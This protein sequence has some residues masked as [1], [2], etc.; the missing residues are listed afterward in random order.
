MQPL[1][2]PL[3]QS[4]LALSLFGTPLFL[5]A[6]EPEPDLSKAIVDAPLVDPWADTIRPISNPTHFDLA[7]PQTLIHPIFIHNQMPDTVD[8]I[9]GDVPVGGDFQLYAVQIEFALNERLSI[10]ATKDGYIDFNPDNTLE[11]T[12]GWANVAAGLKYAWL[13]QPEERFA[14]NIQLLYEIPMG[15]RDVWQGEGDGVFIP[16]VSTLKHFGDLQLAHQFGFKLPV[17]DGAE[18]TMFYTS[19]HASFKLFDWLHPLAEINWFNVID[20]GDGGQRFNTH[21]GGALPSV[22][23]FEAGDLVN[24]G[25]ANADRNRNFVSAA[26]GFRVR[27]PDRPIDLGFAWEMPLTDRDRG[28]LEDRFT[29]DMVIRF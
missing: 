24:W 28:L 17:D 21:I 19:A 14:S 1:R 11:D 7:I 2:I 20:E 16:S 10:N 3:C 23:A 12:D 4:A 27:V 29:V 18:S 8:T 22:V 15:N 9:I 26:L 5:Q 25:A 13:Y 6:G